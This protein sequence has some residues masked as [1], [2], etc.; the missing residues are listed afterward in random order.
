MTIPL[1]RTVKKVIC[2]EFDPRMAAE[3][4]KR[5]QSLGLSH[6]L[7]LIV[8]DAMKVPFPRVDAVLSNLPY[9]ISSPFIFKLLAQE[10]GFR[11]AVIMMQREFCLRLVAKP[12]SPMY[13]RLSANVQLLAKVDHIMKVS[14]NSFRPPPKVES[15]VVRIEQRNPRP[16]VDFLEWDGLARLCFSR[17]NKTL[18][19]VF[20]GKNVLKMLEKNYK[21]YCSLN[22]VEPDPRPIKELVNEVLDSGDFAGRRA[23]KMDNDDLLALLE[24]F[25][26]H[27]IHFNA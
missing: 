2:I 10:R 16:P 15:S 25:N 12:G 26:S 14:R 22:S 1:L 18:G 11:C 7:E 4:T 9:Q 24:A 3:I 17:K 21:T 8:G 13:C 19:A 6:K 5:A 23:A 20:R 27:N